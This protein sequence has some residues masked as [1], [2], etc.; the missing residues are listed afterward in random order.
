M[1]ALFNFVITLGIGVGLTFL[2]NLAVRESTLNK[3]LH[4]ILWAFNGLI[5]LFALIVAFGDATNTDAPTLSAVIFAVTGILASLLLFL[6][7]RQMIAGAFPRGQKAKTE[8]IHDID[9]IFAYTPMMSDGE[10]FRPAQPLALEPEAPTAKGIYTGFDPRNPVHTLALVFSVYIFGLQLGIF[11][12]AGGIAGYADDVSID[13]FTLAFN[14]IPMLAIPLVGVGAFTRRSWSGIA[15]RLGLGHL[16]IESLAIGALSAI[17]LIFVQIFMAW[18]WLALAGQETFENQSEASQ[19]ISD[20]IN[21]IWLALGVAFTAAVGEEIAF[22]GALQPIFGLRWTAVIFTLIHMQYTFT[23]A[24]LIIL[25]V[26]LGF[27]WLRQRYNLYASI[28]AHFVYNFLPL[29]FVV[30]VS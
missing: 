25:V 30:A 10:I 18:I 4:A 3:L 5:M 1:E 20:S 27:G 9:A 24:A 6:P 14:F 28:M 22:R 16:T 26:A 29:L 12:M 21:T 2:A 11:V 7:F 17:I 15:K 23:P 13:A 8:P 19:A